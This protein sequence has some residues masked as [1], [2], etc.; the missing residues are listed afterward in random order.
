MRRSIDGGRAADQVKPYPSFPPLLLMIL[1]LHLLFPDDDGSQDE[2]YR[3]LGGVRREGE[4]R[5]ELKLASD[6]KCE[7]QD[8]FERHT[9][10]EEEME[11]RNTTH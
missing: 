10:Q 6:L 1:L 4:T 3:G 2:W 9:E 11:L 5:W 8:I 7:S